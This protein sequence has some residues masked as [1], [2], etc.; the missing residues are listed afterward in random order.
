MLLS[1]E[2]YDPLSL[3]F[4]LKARAANYLD[5][6]LDLIRSPY[7]SS[8]E[9]RSLFQD[10]DRSLLYYLNCLIEYGI[11]SCCEAIAIGIW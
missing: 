8:P 6:V 1:R 7:P 2:A 10:L 3:S 9:G 11:G 4:Y 5:Q